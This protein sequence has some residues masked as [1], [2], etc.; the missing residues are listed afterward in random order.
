MMIELVT[1]FFTPACLGSCHGWVFPD[2]AYFGLTPG[3]FSNIMIILSWVQV[4]LLCF[5]LFITTVSPGNYRLL[6]SIMP[7]IVRY[8][9]FACML[10]M[11]WIIIVL[12]IGEMISQGNLVP[13]LFLVVII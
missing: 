13:Y 4:A 11:P 12:A 6:N 2:D 3:S 5:S 9:L 1:L 7:T 8:A 10:V